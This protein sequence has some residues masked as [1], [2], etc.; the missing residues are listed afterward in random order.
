MMTSV[1][2][3]GCAEYDAPPSARLVGA[4][5][6][7]L[8][9][10][11][12]DDLVVAFSEPIDPSSLRL[13]IIAAAPG[14]N[15]D[16]EN[17]L[18]DELPGTSGELETLMQFDPGSASGAA[19]TLNED[20]TR[21]RI[22]QIEDGAKL[23]IAKP[24]M[25]LIESGLADLN[26]NATRPRGRLPFI[27]RSFK[28][29]P[30]TL[31][32]GAYYFLMVVDPP[33]LHQQLQLYTHIEVD[34]AN[35][36]FRAKFVDA[37][38]TPELNGREGCPSDCSGLANACRLYPAAE[39]VKP[40]TEQADINNWRDFKPYSKL[41]DGYVFETEGFAADAGDG[42][43][44]LGTEPFQIDIT[45]GAGGVNIIVEDVVFT[46]QMAPD[47]A[48]PTRLRGT[49]SVSVTAVKINGVGDQP[50]KGTLEMMTLTA[51]EEAE[52]VS[53]GNPYPV[54]TPFTD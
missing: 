23:G 15:L 3:T 38:R 7:M 14:I 13:K 50:T 43:I 35:G 27:Y 31:P 53:F 9:G 17:R 11:V 19:F 40:S 48:D 21:L 42:T 34:Q 25:V 6:G 16:A 26:G 22:S 41:P 33:P 46:A 28:P 10:E 18:Q 45:I 2:S 49:G 12:T 54:A 32:S 1:G 47:P 51:A 30:T 5:Q 29:G 8:A 39:C 20:A 4:E 44:N 52:V 37:D 24:Y 36:R